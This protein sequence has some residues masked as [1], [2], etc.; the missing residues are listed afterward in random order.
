MSDDKNKMFGGG[1]L[2]GIS[3]DE[4]E[5][6]QD[7]YEAILTLKNPEELN[8]FFKDLCS[9]NEI[10]SFLHRWQIVKLLDEGKSYDEILR[11]LTPDGDGDPAGTGVMRNKTTVSSTTIARVK[12][13]YVNP[14]GGYRTALARL[15]KKRRS[16]KN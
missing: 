3:S 4:S 16:G 7:L 13:C 5:A 15:E 8:R 12:K 2:P 6:L 9:V 10:Y 11:E 1:V 14:E